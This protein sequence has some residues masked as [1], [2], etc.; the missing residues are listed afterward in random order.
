[1]FFPKCR[2]SPRPDERHETG[3]VIYDAVSYLSSLRIS[4]PRLPRRHLVVA[5]A[6]LAG[7]LLLLPSSVTADH[8]T[9]AAK[10]AAADIQAAR[11]RA[12]AA[13][14]AMFDA[15]S[16]IDGLDLDI[17]AAE[18]ELAALEA[19]A[20]DMQRGLEDQAV[21]S[22]VGAGTGSEFP[23]LINLDEIN[24]GLTA[25]VMS[26]VSRETAN[27]DPY[28]NSVLTPLF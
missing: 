5:A 10:Q 3:P 8:G 24:D 4:T 13:S 9:D 21:R 26:A 15:E 11:D 1:M 6:V 23:L 19:Q 22:F 16:D 25:D 20:A 28:L 2:E 18:V 17:A 7:S 14:Q 27:V 12:N